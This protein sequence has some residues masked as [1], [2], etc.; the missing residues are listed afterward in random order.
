MRE[1]K[2]AAEISEFEPFWR[3][4]HG[5]LKPVGYMLR[6]EG[7]PN[8]VRF[9]S[10]PL[11]KRYAETSDE[12]ATLIARQNELAAEVLGE[13]QPCWLIQSHWQT[14]EG[15]VDVADEHDPFWATREYQLTS[16]FKFAEEDD[17]EAMEWLAYAAQS[18]WKRGRF[19]RLL[20][21]R[22]D[23]RAGPTLWMSKST[24]AVFAPYDGGVDLFLSA[25]SDVEAISARHADWLSTH[26]LGL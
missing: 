26:P 22:A 14:P 19:D 17:D 2:P 12:W 8:W 7:A 23:E 18:V 20:R 13:N 4:H 5:R 10:L 16:A 25:P 6:A 15:L 11:S 1:V 9:H 21:D 24:G 3:L